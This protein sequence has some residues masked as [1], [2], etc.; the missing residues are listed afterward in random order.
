MNQ[1]FRGCAVSGTFSGIDWG[2]WGDKSCLGYLFS[3]PYS[4]EEAKIEKFSGICAPSG[5]SE[6]IERSASCKSGL[7]EVWVKQCRVNI[8]GGFST[9]RSVGWVTYKRL[10]LIYIPVPQTQSLYFLISLQPNASPYILV[11][12]EVVFCWSS[13]VCSGSCPFQSSANMH[14]F[15]QLHHTMPIQVSVFHTT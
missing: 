8:S 5:E 9:I 2:A 14:D 6:G 10:K 7:E 11:L 13:A 3:L 4:A 15:R 1:I 12:I